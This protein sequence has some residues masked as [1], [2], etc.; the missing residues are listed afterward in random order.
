MPDLLERLKAAFADRWTIDS[1]ISRGGMATV[2]LAED[3]K[4]HR[5]VASSLL[6]TPFDLQVASDSP[7]PALSDD[8]F[9]SEDLMK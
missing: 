1:E 4:H 9:S 5:K 3:L 8:E 2:F 7:N 6:P